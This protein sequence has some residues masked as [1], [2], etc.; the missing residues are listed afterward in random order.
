MNK[1]IIFLQTFILLV[2][3]RNINL[4]KMN[5]VRLVG[6]INDKLISKTID[7]IY[8]IKLHELYIYID[9]PGG[10]VY[11]GQKLINTIEYMK[12]KKNI[13]CIVQQ[14]MSM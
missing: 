8:K 5:T 1:Q 11:E 13:S 2:N 9:T 14:A 3:A 6:E 10:S 4:N 7:D 12:D